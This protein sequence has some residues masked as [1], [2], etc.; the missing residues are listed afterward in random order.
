[1]GRD[2]AVSLGD[3][4]EGRGAQEVVREVEVRVIEEVEG[5]G[6]KL[7]VETFA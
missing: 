7:K 1:M 4:A 3:A 5:L 6:P 2:D